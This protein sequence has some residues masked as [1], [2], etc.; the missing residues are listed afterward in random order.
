MRSHPAAAPEPI[1]GAVELFALDPDLAHLNHGSYGAVP[2]EVQH[3]QARL[4][5]V[6]EA[7]PD[8]FLRAAPEWLAQA[9]TTVARW[10]GA[11]EQGLALLGNVTEA[12]AVVLDSIP[13]QA[14]EEILVL[15]HGYGVVNLAAERR[16]AE[17]GARLRTVALP[18]SGVEPAEA[19]LAA[20]GPRT[21]LA[22][23]DRVTSPTAREIATPALLRALAERGVLTAVDAAHGP[24][25]LEAELDVGRP[26]FWFGNLHKWAFAPRPTAVLVVR[27]EWRE[28]IRPL[29]Y[30]WEHGRGYPANVE[31]R[32]TADYTGWLA[33]PSGL[34]LLDRLGLARV[35]EH[36]A[37]LAAYGQRVLGEVAGLSALPASP[38]V[39]MRALRLPPGVAETEEQVPVLMEAIHERL[40]ARVAVRPW[41]G[42]GVLRISAQVY[43]RAEEY[44]ALAVGLAELLRPPAPPRS[45]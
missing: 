2:I 14:G 33:A 32:G 27:P 23:L 31:W 29:T 1:R 5:A 41:A 17:C 42:G 8:G 4:R 3:E 20:V 35:R 30:S 38:G 43:N 7:D 25:M 24:G 45:A 26:D 21:R 36:N 12:V 34:A 9:R 44:Q 15:D 10:L 37:R 28:R 22:V 6:Q 16:A 19:V 18:L 40:G 13:F 39:A 11:D